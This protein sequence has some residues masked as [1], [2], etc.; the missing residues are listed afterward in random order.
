MSKEKDAY[1]KFNTFFEMQNED[2]KGVSKRSVPRRATQ[3]V[4]SD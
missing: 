2:W 1:F 4:I 3:Q